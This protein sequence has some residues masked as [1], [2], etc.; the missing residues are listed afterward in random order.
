MDVYLERVHQEDRV[1]VKNV[2]AAI[3]A[4]KKG[5][6]F[7]SWT[8]DLGKGCYVGQENTARMNWRQKVN[9]RL[10]VVPL[11]QSDEKRRKIAYPQLGLAVEHR[12][13]EDIDPAAAPEWLRA[14]LAS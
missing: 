14:A 13:T 12:R 3:E 9:R 8:C 1:I 7:T 2:I 6:L 11:A 5:K 10:I 4:M